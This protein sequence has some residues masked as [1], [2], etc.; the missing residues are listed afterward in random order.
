MAHTILAIF[1][2]CFGL[3]YNPGKCQLAP[4]RCPEEHVELATGL[5]PCQLVAFPVK[6]LGIPLSIAKLPRSVLQPLVEQ[7]ADRLPT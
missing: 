1:K 5:F 4:I 2:H 3:N 7:V 6:Y